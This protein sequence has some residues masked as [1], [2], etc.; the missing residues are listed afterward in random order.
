MTWIFGSSDLQS[1]SGPFNA[2]RHYPKIESPSLETLKLISRQRRLKI[3]SHKYP[4]IQK[5]HRKMQNAKLITR[6]RKQKIKIQGHVPN[7][8]KNLCRPICA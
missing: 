1:A 2:C 3:Y 5:L 6:K 4:I 8:W 7:P